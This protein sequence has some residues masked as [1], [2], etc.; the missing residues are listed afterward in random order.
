MLAMFHD[1]VSLGISLSGHE[2]RRRS[3]VD[4]GVDRRAKPRRP[5]AMTLDPTCRRSSPGPSRA[6]IALRMAGRIAGRRMS[7]VSLAFSVVALACAQPNVPLPDEATELD[8]LVIEE[9][10]A[11][12]VPGLQAAVI[13]DGAVAQVHGWGWADTETRRLVDGTDTLFTIASVSK[14]VTTVAVM[15]QVEAGTLTL[16]APLDVGF[17]VAHPTAS[18]PITLRHL[19]THT[20]AIIDNWDVT[21]PLYSEGDPTLGLAE[22]LEAYLR[23]DGPYYAEDNWA[24]WAPATRF[25]YSNVAIALAAVAVERAT[26]RDFEAYCQTAIFEPLGMDATSWYFRGIDLARLAVPTRWDRGWKPEPHAGYPDYPNGSLKTSAAQLGL[27]AVAVTDSDRGF[28]QRATID[29]MLRIQDAA[30]EPTQ[31]LG[32]YWWTLDGVDVVGHNGGE[33]GISSELL[34]R[35]EHADGVV[36]LA[37]G[38]LS[39]AGFRRI[40]RALLE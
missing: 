27:F 15:Q 8:R 4:V 16:D 12:G 26:G 9:L 2:E 38:E 28:L 19:L 22:F 35:P 40:Q 32:F 17:P 11:D 24:D 10:E 25:E 14:L 33:D 23:P 6:A 7:S 5:H 20:S 37:N 1:T 30:I 29:E 36:L 39:E 21:E 3:A 13:R 31:A 34:L 18:T